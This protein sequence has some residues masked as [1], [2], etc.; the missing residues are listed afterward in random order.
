MLLDIDSGRGSIRSNLAPLRRGLISRT[1]RSVLAH[2]DEARKRLA[3]SDEFLEAA[4]S[5]LRR[6][7]PTPAAGAAYYAA[8]HAA[9]A[10]L[11]CCNTG[12]GQRGRWDHGHVQTRFMRAVRAANHPELAVAFERLYTARI[13]ADYQLRFL[14]ESEG[15]D[16]VQYA[17]SVIAFCKIEVAQPPAPATQQGP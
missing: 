2:D 7:A 13:V 9:I 5:D 14:R 16:A 3:K 4:H 6:H 8:Y 12:P 11:R 10:Y 15:R 17:E 1:E